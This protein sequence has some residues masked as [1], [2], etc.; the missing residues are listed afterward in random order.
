[1]ND[2]AAAAARLD[3]AA[4]QACIDDAMYLLERHRRH[5]GRLVGGKD[6]AIESGHDYNPSTIMEYI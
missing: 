1:M 2:D 6:F 4:Q 3:T 5:R